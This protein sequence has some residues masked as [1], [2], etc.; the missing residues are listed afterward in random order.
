MKLSELKEQLA[1]TRTRMSGFFCRTGMPFPRTRTSRRWRA[2]T[3][4]SWIA[5]APC[6]MI[7]C[8]GCKHGSPMTWITGSRRVSSSKFWTR[9]NHFWHRMILKWMSNTKSGSSASFPWSRSKSCRMKLSFI[10][11]HDTR[12]VWRWINACPHAKPASD[13]SPLKFNFREQPESAGCC[14]KTKIN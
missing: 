5:A 11:A 4:G 1:G 3:N 8:A 2:L 13:F 14:T 6:G 12:P 10:W 7:P 9:R